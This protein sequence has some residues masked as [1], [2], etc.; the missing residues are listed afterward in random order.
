MLIHTFARGLVNASVLFFCLVTW[1]RP[2][3]APHAL[4]ST[5]DLRTRSKSTLIGCGGVQLTPL[6]LEVEA[7]I[8]HLVNQERAA[9]DL[10]PLKGIS[11]LADAARY[12]S[13]DM[14]ED[15]YFSHDSYDRIDEELIYT[16]STWE[17]ISTFY[18]GASGENIAAGFTSPAEVMQAWMASDGHR[19]NILSS[20][21]WEIGVGYWQG[22]GTYEYYYTQDFGRRPG[23]FPLVINQDA[24]T[25]DQREVRIYVYG[26]WTEMRL[27][28]DDQSWGEWQP[29]QPEFDWLLPNILGNH[30][31]Y[32]ELLSPDL[33]ASS[34]DSIELTAVDSVAQLA[35]LPDS[36][37]FLYSE[38]SQAWLPPSMTLYPANAGSTDPITWQVEANLTW[39]SIDPQF[40]T[41]P[42]CFTITPGSEVISPTRT[43]SGTITVV[44]LTPLE[45]IDSPH[46]I[47]IFLQPSESSFYSLYL[48]NI[49]R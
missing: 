18:S 12:H 46:P 44:S 1:T 36:I 37:T 31:V 3:I 22:D 43:L 27:R 10:P 14:S 28:N 5:Q 19:A 47:T 41:T 6:A 21:P 9:V 39:L 23:V 48:P 26:D 49:P 13:A 8:V 20:Y 11:D 2:F 38:P 15:D 24:L 45:V 29:F 42:D 17:R 30:T 40:G 33:N 25:T 4:A 16:C 7:E 32:I 35:N 34:T